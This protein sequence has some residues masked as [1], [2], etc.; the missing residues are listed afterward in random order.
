MSKDPTY[1]ELKHEL[2]EARS[3]FARH[4]KDFE[5]ISKLCDSALGDDAGVGPEIYLRYVFSC[6]KTIRSIVG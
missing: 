6:L 2:A 1:E 5:R 4:H 3:E